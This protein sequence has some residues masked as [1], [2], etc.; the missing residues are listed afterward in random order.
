MRVALYLENLLV[1]GAQHA[2]IDL[3][4]GLAERGHD[5]TLVAGPG[6]LAAIAAERGVRL[7]RLPQRAHPGL[8]S[9]RAL[10]RVLAERRSDVVLAVGP[11]AAIEAVTAVAAAR[12]Q[13]VAVVAAYP[14]DTLSPDAPRTTP[15]LTRRPA[16]L[17]AARRRNPVVADVPAAVDTAY[18]AP[19]VDGGAFRRAHTNEDEALVVLATRLAREQKATGIRTSIRATAELARRRPVRLVIAGDGGLR[20]DV[21]AEAE[22]HGG[23]AVTLVGELVDPRP[24]YAAADVVLGLGTS[25]LRGMA[26]ARPSIALG[27]E[28]QAR[29][30]DAAAVAD[31]A[32]TGWLADGP[33][34]AP[35][36][37]ADLIER[38]LDDPKLA[39]SSAAAGRAAVTEERGASVVAALVEPVLADAV[40]RPTGRLRTGLDAARSWAGWWLR[41]TTGRLWRR[42][43]YRYRKWAR[44]APD[45]WAR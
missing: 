7:T 32:P 24:A 9:A 15:V 8:R 4:I 14:S 5:V 43:R 20:P 44:P 36:E 16:V 37:L 18:N 10:V 38:L 22:R 1:G 26:M 35:A 21:E 23:G 30:V 6:P 41:P 28:G 40:A 11:S 17:A 12:R 39:R 27:A 3:A 34:V 33:P 29:V 31:L 42:V 2:T 45:P 13:P 19:G 25:V